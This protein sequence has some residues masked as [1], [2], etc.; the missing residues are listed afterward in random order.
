MHLDL[1]S[2]NNATS[3]NVCRHLQKRAKGPPLLRG[4]TEASAS[5]QGPHR[6]HRHSAYGWCT[7]GGSAVAR[8]AGWEA[9]VGNPP[10]PSPRRGGGLAEGPGRASYWG[11]ADQGNGGGGSHPFV[12]TGFNGIVGRRISARQECQPQRGWQGG[13]GHNKSSNPPMKLCLISG[14]AAGNLQAEMVVRFDS[15]TL[16]MAGRGSVFRKSLK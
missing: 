7:K 8:N 12:G 11:L 9:A 15:D 6:L 5:V 1:N 2:V 4:Q 10:D 16:E 3:V 13:D 14:S